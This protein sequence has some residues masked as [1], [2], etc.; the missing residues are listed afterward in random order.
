MKKSKKGID[1]LEIKFEGET[2][3]DKGI[4]FEAKSTPSLKGGIDIA[5]EI[6]LDI[7]KSKENR[8]TSAIKLDMKEANLAGSPFQFKGKLPLNLKI[9]SIKNDTFDLNNINTN[10]DGEISCVK[11]KCSFVLKKPSL[12]SADN[13]IMKN[14]K[15]RIAFEEGV[16]NFNIT[17]DNNAPLIEVNDENIIEY[18]FN[19]NDTMLKGS[20]S[21]GFIIKPIEMN[22]GLASIK[23]TFNPSGMINEINIMSDGGYYSDNLIGIAGLRTSVFAK[24]DLYPA[25]K[26]SGEEVHFLGKETLV[27]IFTGEAEL[28]PMF[29]GYD[30]KVLLNSLKRDLLVDIKGEYNLTDDT[31]K[32]SLKIPK[33]TFADGGAQ[34]SNISPHFAKYVARFNGSLAVNSNG[35]INNG[36]F[37]GV[38]KLLVENSSFNWGAVKFNNLNGV[39]GFKSFYPII[40]DEEQTLYASMIDIGYPVYDN[41]MTFRITG[42]N[43]II[44]DDISSTLAN[45]SIKLVEK[46]F[47]PFNLSG[48]VLNTVIKGIDLGDL[49]RNLKMTGLS[50]NGKAN[51][52]AQFY[53]S[54]GFI[55]TDSS[56]EAAD[57]GLLKYVFDDFMFDNEEL[58]EQLKPLSDFNYD[59]IV[60]KIKGRPNTNNGEA[61]TIDLELEG[62]NP[63]IHKDGIGTLIKIDL[64]SN[65]G[66][67]VKLK[68]ILNPVPDKVSK[69]MEA[70]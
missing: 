57:K 16:T 13:I 43:R 66:E 69:Q 28:N 47:I 9:S 1:L 25:I 62:L 30:F 32:Y 19:I 68:P 17:P 31:G 39:I 54:R 67:L 59:R 61:Y 37:D 65:L 53:I 26:V 24:T 4:S 52:K 51:G 70:F 22:L 5:S 55:Y 40:T 11:Q 49:T 7:D 3:D 29:T 12:L 8:F 48:G 18:S 27:P 60:A 58:K 50:I 23:G 41:T 38:T 45:G 34:L 21:S 44:V 42:N 10:L 2:S 14:P 6:K 64:Q 63:E 33:I 15:H 56:I 46:S 36:S 35:I 20:Y